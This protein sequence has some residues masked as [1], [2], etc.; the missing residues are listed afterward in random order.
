MFLLILVK[1]HTLSQ[2]QS[3][4]CSVGTPHTMRCENCGEVLKEP[5]AKTAND[6]T[7]R[8]VSWVCDNCGQTHNQTITI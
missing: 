6:K 1:D 5:T 3:T 8:S 2:L 7:N 4:K